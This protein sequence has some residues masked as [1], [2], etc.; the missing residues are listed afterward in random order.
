[1]KLLKGI[2]QKLLCAL[3][4]HENID[5][6]LYPNAYPECKIDKCKHCDYYEWR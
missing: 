5:W 2:T 3:G 4:Y 6:Q 1:V